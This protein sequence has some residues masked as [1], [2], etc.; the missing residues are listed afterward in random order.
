MVSGPFSSYT[1]NLR[2]S[3]P[4]GFDKTHLE[5][6][7]QEQ[8]SLDEATVPAGVT[9]RNGKRALLKYCELLLGVFLGIGILLSKDGSR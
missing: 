7:I 6:Q 3:L 8:E 5:E 9:R 1:I 4:T 2:L